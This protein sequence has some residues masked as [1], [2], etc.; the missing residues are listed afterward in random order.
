VETCWPFAVAVSLWYAARRAEA[1][2]AGPGLEADD[3]MAC[4]GTF[5]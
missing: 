2:A 3:E 4:P 1:D 5:R